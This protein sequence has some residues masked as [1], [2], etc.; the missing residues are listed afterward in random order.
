MLKVAPTMDA[1]HPYD[2]PPDSIDPR[3]LADKRP[4]FEQERR[5]RMAMNPG[6]N[7]K[8]G[9]ALVPNLEETHK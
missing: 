4:A 6:T 7:P 3:C 9:K 2:I 1:A 5:L 8:A